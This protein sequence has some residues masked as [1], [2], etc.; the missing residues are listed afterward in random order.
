MAQ[1]VAVVAAGVKEQAD[2][3]GKQQEVAGVGEADAPCV[4]VE[5]KQAPPAVVVIRR[6][7]EA[8]LLQRQNAVHRN[9]LLQRVATNG[10]RKMA[11]VVLRCTRAGMIIDVETVESYPEGQRV[12][13]GRLAVGLGFQQ[14]GFGPNTLAQVQLSARSREV[15]EQCTAQYEQQ[16]GVDAPPAQAAPAPSSLNDHHKRRQGQYAP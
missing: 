14:E 6:L 9:R 10:Y 3:R 4:A 5:G 12:R 13:D 7:I 11:H 15:G 8:D 1:Q 16:G 2:E